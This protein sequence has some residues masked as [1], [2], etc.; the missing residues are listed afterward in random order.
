[1]KDILLNYLCNQF[2]KNKHKV[3]REQLIYFYRK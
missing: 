3:N 1:L 2:I